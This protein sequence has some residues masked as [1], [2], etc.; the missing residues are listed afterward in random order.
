MEKLPVVAIRYP[1]LSLLSPA[2]LRC[3]FAASAFLTVLAYAQTPSPAPPPLLHAQTSLVVVD[4]MVTDSYR[5]PV[6]GLHAKDFSLREDGHPEMVKTF[7]EHS[8][9]Q[10]ASL[11]QTLTPPPHLNSGVFTNEFTQPASGALNLILLDQ[12]NTTEANQEWVREQVTGYLRTAPEGARFAILVLNS[13]QLPLI[14]GFT[15]NRD[16]LVAAVSGKK[17]APKYP[18]YLNNPALEGGPRF[19]TV[20][21]RAARIQRTLD[22]LNQLCRYLGQIPGRK[23]LLWF[24]SSFPIAILPNGE[25]PQGVQPGYVDEFTETVNLLSHYQV[26]VFPISASGLTTEQPLGSDGNPLIPAR[27]PCTLPAAGVNLAEATGGQAFKN[28]NDLEQAAS[29]AVEAGSNYY[30]IAYAPENHN[31]NGKY[32]KIQI[33]VDRKGLTLAYRRG[34]YV[35]RTDHLPPVEEGTRRGSSRK[36]SSQANTVPCARQWF[37]CSRAF[38]KFP[39]RHCSAKHFG[40]GIVPLSAQPTNLSREGPVSSLRRPLRTPTSATFHCDP[41]PQGA[42]NCAVEF[43]TCVYNDDGLLINTQVNDIRETVTA[44]E[45]AWLHRAGQMPEDSVHVRNQRTNERSLPFAA[46]H[47]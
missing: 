45:F 21:K 2:C 19:S 40:R 42:L 27:H 47:P 22:S 29:R 33:E 10:S 4:V 5:N 11:K 25:Y 36:A 8:A 13:E 6:H 17:A 20:V 44:D 38:C 23:N 24:S 35:H 37:T 31:W 3:L 26:A 34:D 12:L 30:T 15:S 28:T 32:R 46:R 9:N 16:L 43:V 14:Q 1:E 41:A 39:F 7:E 18:V